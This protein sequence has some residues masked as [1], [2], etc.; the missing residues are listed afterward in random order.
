MLVKYDICETFALVD[1][2][3][4]FIDISSSS[5]SIPCGCEFFYILKKVFSLCLHTIISQNI[6]INM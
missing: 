4:L 2:I 1:L 6:G 5:S 3:K